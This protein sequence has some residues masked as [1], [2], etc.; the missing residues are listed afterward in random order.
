[1]YETQDE[2]YGCL[3]NINTL[4]VMDGT[5]IKMCENVNIT[6]ENCTSVHTITF[7]INDSLSEI[8][9]NMIKA[10]KILL[11]TSTAVAT[12]E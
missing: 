3:H 4:N 6:Q 9:R 1:M 10:L 2:I 12:A 11:T 5:D 7:I 8:C